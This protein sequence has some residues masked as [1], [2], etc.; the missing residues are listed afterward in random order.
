V[1]VNQKSKEVLMRVWKKGN[2]NIEMV[3]ME[4]GAAVMAQNSM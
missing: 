2:F 3:A 4:I 1:A